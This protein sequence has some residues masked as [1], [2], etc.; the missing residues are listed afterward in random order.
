MPEQE[1]ETNRVVHDR[2]L[3]FSDSKQIAFIGYVVDTDSGLFKYIRAYADAKWFTN[4]IAGLLYDAV[5][6]YWDEYKKVPSHQELLQ[7]PKLNK[8]AEIQ[9][10][11]QVTLLRAVEERKAWNVDALKSET[12]VWM[13]AKILQD[14]GEKA[15]ALFNAEKFEDTARCYEQGHKAYNDARFDLGNFKRAI[16]IEELRAGQGTEGVVRFGLTGVDDILFPRNPRGG[17]R[18]GDQTLAMAPSNMGKTS[19]L[20]TVGIHNVIAGNKVLVVTHQGRDTDIRVKYIRCFLNLMPFELFKEILGSPTRDDVLGVTG[21]K[22][23]FSLLKPENELFLRRSFE[24]LKGIG[25]DIHEFLLGLAWVDQRASVLRKVLY[26]LDERLV[27]ASHHKAFLT[28]E[29]V[30]PILDRAQEACNDRWGKGFDIC[31]DDYPGCLQTNVNS[32]GNYQA[33][34][35]LDIVYEAFT[36][37][38]LAKNWH[39]LVAV[40][41]NREGSKKASGYDGFGFGASKKENIRFLRNEDIAEAWGPITGATNVITVNRS[42]DAMRDRTLTFFIAKSRSSITNVAVTAYEDFGRC[43]THADELGWISYQLGHEDQRI[44]KDFMKPGVGRA[45]TLDEVHAKIQDAKGIDV[46]AV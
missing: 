12:Q 23:C 18:K 19:T 27:Y 24:G 9:N 4:P 33:R 38:A 37:T 30:I 28:V 7:W 16:E 14:T 41:T 15:A 21:Q 46:K 22:F 25:K 13:Q 26:W 34:Q 2:P 31:I 11:M 42:P 17:L 20:L 32:R 6:R 3:P 40:Q 45:L 8:D 44:I 35:V 29:E 39:S 1:Q 5:R 43:I 10:R 36:Q